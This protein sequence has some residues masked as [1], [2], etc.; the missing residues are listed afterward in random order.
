MFFMAQEQ[1]TVFSEDRVNTR[2]I[3]IPYVDKP[4][5][6]VFYNQDGLWEMREVPRDVDT[7]L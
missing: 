3:E 7:K 2:V 4:T 6:A 5:M 1:R